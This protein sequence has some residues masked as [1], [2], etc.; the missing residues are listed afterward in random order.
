[1]MEAA[2]RI[3][4]KAVMAGTTTTIPVVHIAPGVPMVDSPYKLG[5]TYT[6]Q[7]GEEV[8]FVTIANEGT[9]YEAMGDQ[10]GVYRYTRRDWGRVCGS[11][12]DYSDPRNVP[13][14][15]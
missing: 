9:T 3:A 13:K 12:H 10:H 11:P 1:M 5:E 7:G 8:I 15:A 6:T 2:L 14:P 4:H